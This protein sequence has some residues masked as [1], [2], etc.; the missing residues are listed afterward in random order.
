MA[1]AVLQAG[2]AFQGATGGNE[3]EADSFPLEYGAVTLSEPVLGAP[4]RAS[5]QAYAPLGWIEQPYREHH[6]GQ[7]RD[8]SENP[9]NRRPLDARHHLHPGESGC[10]AQRALPMRFSS[11]SVKGFTMVGVEG[12]AAVLSRSAT[13]GDLSESIGTMPSG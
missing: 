7:Q 11:A 2:Q 9:E 1:F 4:D 12:P 3:L 10:N 6:C 13:L 8:P 5:G